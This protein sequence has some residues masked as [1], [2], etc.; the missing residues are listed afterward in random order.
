ML[1][2][3]PTLPALKGR[4]PFR[5]GT[6]SYILPDA[7]VPNVRFIGPYVDEVE[8]VFFESRFPDSLPTGKDI[9]ELNRLAGEYDLSYNVHL[10]TDVFLGHQDSG[11]RQQAC[12]TILRFYERTLPLQPTLYVL[13]LEKNPPENTKHL[14]T[15]DWQGNLLFSLEY[16][17][18]RGMES[19]LTGIENLDYPFPWIYPLI[20][21][22]HL[23]ICLDIG[24]LLVQQEELT[25]YIA[26][27]G[28]EISMLHL[29]GAKGHKDHQSLREI[30][31]HDWH[32][33]SN[34][35]INYR[36]GVSLEVFSRADLTASL[37]RMSDLLTSPEDDGLHK[38]AVP[39]WTGIGAEVRNPERRA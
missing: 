20:R 24:H 3:S 9:E 2:P 29:H 31:P 36:G 18:E 22:L 12:D 39:D 13:H 32:I 17:L 10:P 27:Y 28:N 35:L 4:F 21:E 1:I 15:S 37:E 6:T 7:I 19:N 34:F 5:L 16:L 8:L 30:S 38:L 11:M 14:N 25:P 33:I 26:A 23:S